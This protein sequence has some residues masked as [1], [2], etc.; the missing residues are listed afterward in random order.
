MLSFS[1]NSN[2][3]LPEAQFPEDMQ[4]CRTLSHMQVYV[5]N[6]DSIRRIKSKTYNMGAVVSKAFSLNGG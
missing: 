4:S 1:K 3:V 5:Y 2:R 6:I